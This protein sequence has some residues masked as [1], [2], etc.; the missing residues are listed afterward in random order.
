[1]CDLKRRKLV[2]VGIMTFVIPRI[3]F[4]LAFGAGSEA[5]RINIHDVF[6]Q[7]GWIGDGEEYNKYISFSSFNVDNPHS[8]PLCIKIS[9]QF[10]PSKWAGIYWQNEPNNWGDEPGNDYSRKSLR[11]LTFWA[12]G[13]AGGEVV[14]FKSGGINISGKRYKDSYVASTGSQKLTKEWKQYEIDLSQADLSSVI[15]G[16]CWIAR[17]EDN[18]GK[19]IIFYLDDIYFE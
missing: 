12:R 5:N 1:M 3:F 8:A 16:F 19:E 17:A 10:G 4:S 18:T 14:E 11:K 13:E 15:G 9:Y 2:C 6:I 7:S